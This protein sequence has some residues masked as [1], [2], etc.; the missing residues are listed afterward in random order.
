MIE[1]G[2]DFHY[3]SG[4]QGTGNTLGDLYQHTNY[5]ADGRQALIHIY[6]SQGWQR[7]WVPEYFCYEVIES[8][9]QAGLNLMFY[10]DWPGNDDANLCSSMV[11]GRVSC[12][13]R[14]YDNLNKVVRPSDAVLRVN[15]FGTRSYRSFEKLPV[16]AVIEDHTHDLIGD[17]PMHSTA[18]WCIASLRKSLPIPEGGMLWSPIGLKLASA[19]KVSEENER[20]AT[21]RWEAMKLKARYLAGEAVEKAEFRK[22]YVETEEYFDHAQFCA[23]DK[24]SQDYLKRFD[25]HSWYNQKR[26]NWELLR[27]IKKD[28]VHVICPESKGSYPFSLV[29]LFDN[30]EE[31][32]RVRRELIEHQIYPAVLWN[33]P[34]TASCE[35]KSFSR[36]ML[37]IHC[38]AR[39]TRDDIQQMKTII[40]SIL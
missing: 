32:E 7:L 36:R 38:D 22:G 1:F 15:Y 30:P 26:E 8:L 10:T 11:A 9:K 5:Y 27:A 12:G 18:D 4:F 17:W 20:I 13:A 3:I 24:A 6:H 34:D 14:Q 28:G 21:I 2:S 35:V 40:E 29:L 37:S 39:Y 16:A 19:P 33:V 31:R 25:I 23:L